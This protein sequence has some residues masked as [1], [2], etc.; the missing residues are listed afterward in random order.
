MPAAV[1]EGAV[2]VFPGAAFAAR[3]GK[4]I[5]GRTCAGAKL[6]Y[7]YFHDRL[8]CRAAEVMLVFL[9]SWAGGPARA[10]V[11]A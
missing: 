3:M 1:C 4:V 9:M 7:P 11:D 5:A 2:G 6:M 10:Q 8:L